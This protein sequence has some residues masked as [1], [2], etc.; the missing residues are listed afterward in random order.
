MLLPRPESHTQLEAGSAEV[1]EGGRFLN[2]IIRWIKRKQ[3]NSEYFLEF[4]SLAG[5]YLTAWEG[6]EA[7]GRITIF[8]VRGKNWNGLSKGMCF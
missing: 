5:D 2:H 6:G 1:E 3:P 4:N 7:L 8:Y